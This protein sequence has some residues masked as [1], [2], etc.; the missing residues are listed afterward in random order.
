MTDSAGLAGLLKEGDTVGITAVLVGSSSTYAKVVSE[1][2]RVLFVSPEFRTLDPSQY[3]I[4]EESSGFGSGS[5][6]VPTDRENRGVVVLAVPTDAVLIAYDFAAFGV[7][8]MAK[9]W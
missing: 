3:V 6:T 5:S 2:L 8:S 7:D 4:S 9:T 1:Y